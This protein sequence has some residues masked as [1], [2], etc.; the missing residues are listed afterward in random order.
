M[1]RCRW[2]KKSRAV[3]CAVVSVLDTKGKAALNMTLHVA[4]L[5]ADKPR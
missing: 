2:P 3:A 4:L 5:V 1:V